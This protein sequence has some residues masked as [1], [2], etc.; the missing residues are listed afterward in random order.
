MGLATQAFG[1]APAIEAPVSP[2]ALNRLFAEAE[3]AFAA[4]EYTTAVTKIEELLAALGTN[5]DAPLEL[6]YF[7]LGL[8]NLLAEKPVEAEAGFREHLKRFP[9]GEYA[10]RSY[11]GIGRAAISQATPESKERAI[12]ALRIAAQDP[13]FRSEA[14]LSLGLVYSDLGRRDEALGVFKSLMGSDIR[15]PQQT[16]AAVE[17]LGLLADTGNLVDLILYLDRL[18]NQAGVRDA[19]A[20]YANQVIVRGDE[21]VGAQAYESALALYRSVPPRSQIIEIQKAALEGQRRDLKI[22]EKRVESEKDKPLGQR[23]SAS[24]LLGNLK[25]AIELSEKALAVVEEKA[26]L[27]A[28]LI[29]RRGR[30][31]YYLERHEEALVCFRAIRN[32]H[33]SAPDAQAAAYAEIVILNKL[34]DIPEI[35]VMCDAFLRKYPDSENAEQV[36][37]L[38]G[39]VL[40]QSGNWAE[41]GTFYRGL[42]TKFPKSESLDRYRF[43][44]GLATFQDGNFKE[45]NPVFAKVISEFPTSPLVENALYYVA[46][47][48]FLSN[49]YKKTLS[50]IKEYLSKFPDG[51]YAGDLR[52]RLAFIDFNDKEVD[53][54][55]KII[56]D[57]TAFLKDHPTDTSAG[58]MYCLLADTYKK[59][60]SDKPDE[61]ARFQQLALEAYRNA[62]WSESSDDVIQYALDSATTMMS[63]N[64]DWSGIAALH[65]EFLKRKPENALA[66][67]SATWVAKMKTREGKGAEAAEM[68]ADALRSRIANPTA[69]QVE[70]LIDELVKIM[71]PRKKASEVDLDALD[72][73]LIEVLNKAIEGQENAT[74][75]AR[76]Y[77]AR[78]RLAQMLRRADRSDLYL[79]GIATINAENPVVLS[80]A[81]LAVSG[82][83]LLKLGNLDQAEGMFKRLSERYREGSFSD[84]GPVG[85]GYIALARKQPEEALRIFEDTLVNNPGTSR[86]KETTIGK[87]EALVA[88]GKLEEAEKLA[89]ATAGDKSFRG[90]SAGKALLLMGQIYRMQAEKASA[91]A[92][93]ELLKKAH[94]TYNRVFTAYKSTPEI[95]AEGGWQAYETL[96]E[97][98]DLPLAEETLKTIAAD[99]KLKNT[100][101]AKKASELAP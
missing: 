30:C 19:I 44:Q 61:L 60:P 31:L 14:G 68:M 77:Y 63:G 82:D 17:V 58:S 6:L 96:K 45:S 74:T 20:W 89:L 24:E 88:L 86:F 92:K 15:S 100:E 5:K 18:S 3:A 84:A 11:L 36:A 66:L 101:R 76:L 95:A 37:T 48:N 39:E 80:P 25:P 32:K 21:L 79:K 4:K 35:K 27:D 97:M 38:A 41:V 67:L 90:E 83:I 93:A 12:E 81:L 70:F 75:N 59:K 94:G 29:M 52:Y 8:G 55:D 69:E 73:Q 9:K 64:K 13:K 49:D 40:V 10:S 2:A 16:T 56:K 42:E 99:Q 53:Q 46:M 85:L 23:S 7:N 65:G 33:G 71:V 91:D 98:G 34:Q 43:F 26:D 62:V 51:R 22:L 47:S 1:Q 78:A 87:L 72:K 54:S 28:A 50:S 57:L